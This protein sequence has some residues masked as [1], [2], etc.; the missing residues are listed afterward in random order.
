MLL[1]IPAGQFY[2]ALI[3]D[4]LWILLGIWLLYGWPRR[5]RRKVARG[6]L[7]REA[8]ENKLRTFSP[9]WGYL[10]LF[11]GIAETCVSLNQVKFFR[12]IEVI[13]GVFLLVVSLLI[14]AFWLRQR[15]RGNQ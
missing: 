13:S 2:G 3:E 6:Q 9:K 1:V 15:R 10:A 12:G 4:I 8:A 7:S 14:L 5:I 11:V